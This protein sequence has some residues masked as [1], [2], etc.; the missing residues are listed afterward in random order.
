MRG[1]SGSQ[2]YYILLGGL[3][4]QRSGIIPEGCQQL[5]TIMEGVINRLC[6]FMN[7]AENVF[8]E[9]VKDVCMTL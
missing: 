9:R 2:Y 5:D 8:I 7:K 3:V 6:D 1:H 4:Q